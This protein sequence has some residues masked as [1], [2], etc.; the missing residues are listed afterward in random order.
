MAGITSLLTG[1]SKGTAALYELPVERFTTMV[2][3]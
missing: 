1:E 3:G 2:E